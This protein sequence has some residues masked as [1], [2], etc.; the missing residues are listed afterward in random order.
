MLQGYVGDAKKYTLTYMH[1]ILGILLSFE[2]E[3]YFSEELS[4]FCATN[5]CLC[6]FKTSMHTSYF[7]FVQSFWKPPRLISLGFEPY[8]DLD[9]LKHCEE[10]KLVPVCGLQVYPIR[11]LGPTKCTALMDWAESH[12]VPFL[13]NSG[14]IIT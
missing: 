10:K 2:Q 1:V 5:L 12:S 7:R 11:P 6:V 8:G 14:T 3:E 4:T 9:P 13:M